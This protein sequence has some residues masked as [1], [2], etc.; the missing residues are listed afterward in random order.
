M[1]VKQIQA[2]DARVDEI[3]AGSNFAASAARMADARG[4]SGVEAIQYAAGLVDAARQRV[5][6]DYLQSRAKGQAEEKERIAAILY[7]PAAQ[8]Q[9]GRAAELAFRTDKTADQAIAILR[10]GCA[11]GGGASDADSLAA[12]ILDAGGE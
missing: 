7:S 10:D 12:S 4:L 5:R 8:G 9:E 2:I 6:S 11:S 1:D 3:V